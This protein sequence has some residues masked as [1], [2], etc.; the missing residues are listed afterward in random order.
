M[1]VNKDVKAIADQLGALG[2]KW[3][4]AADA[5]VQAA[6]DAATA[7]VQDKI[8]AAVKTALDEANA[9]HAD[10]VAALQAALDKA[11]PPAAA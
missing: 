3:Q 11:T 5:K 2:D 9:D 8:A 4:A 7:D 10:D 6:V 1:T